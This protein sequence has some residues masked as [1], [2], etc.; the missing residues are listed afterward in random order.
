MSKKFLKI[1]FFL[2]LGFSFYS[3]GD[4][5]KDSDPETFL[6]SCE[7]TWNRYYSMFSIPTD[8][9]VEYAKSTE[10]DKSELKY[11]A[12]QQGDGIAIN[13]S[14]DE[15]DNETINT[16]KTKFLAQCDLRQHAYKDQGDH[17]ENANLE[18]KNVLHVKTTI[19]HD[20]AQKILEDKENSSEFATALSS[21]PADTTVNYIADI[22]YDFLIINETLYFETSGTKYTNSYK[23]SNFKN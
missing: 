19:T 17:I 10:G 7:N 18:G 22:S 15:D 11:K 1:M 13:I 12:N 9:I 16:S 4:D 21:A 14:E 5:K 2:V 20:L 8:W 6:T 3:C 23:A